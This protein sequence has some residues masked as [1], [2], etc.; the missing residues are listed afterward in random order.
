MIE[1]R[2]ISWVSLWRVVAV[3]AI[4]LLGYYAR[5]VLAVVFFALIFFAAFDPVVDWFERKRLGR[6]LGTIFVYLAMLV[7]IVLIFIVIAPV[8]YKEALGAVELIPGYSEKAFNFIAGSKVGQNLNDVLLNYSDSIFKSGSTVFSTLLGL[9]G[10]ITA[11]VSAMLISFYLLARQKSV[12]KLLKTILPQ[13]IELSAIKIWQKVRVRVGRWFRT[14]LLLSLV[15]GVLVYLSLTILGVKYALV[16]GLVAAIFELVPVIGPIFAGAVSALVALTQ[17]LPLAIW[18]LAIFII[19]HQI[20]SNIL[21]PLTMKKSVGLNP[22]MVIVVIL[23]GAKLGG[24]M[25]I[26][27]A[28]P[29]MVIIEEIITELDRKKSTNLSIR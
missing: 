3:V 14:Q 27:F 9:V 29:V 1:S 19:I 4:L 18:T 28:I 6:I 15:V 13:G 2:N 8:I 23:I 22:V 26:I 25:G 7:I 24:A 5:S 12:E 11:A 20:E 10:S 21:V 17:A 16:L